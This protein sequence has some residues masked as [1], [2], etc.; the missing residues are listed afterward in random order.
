MTIKI[1]KTCLTGLVLLFFPTQIFGQ[2][3]DLGAIEPFTLFTVD[4]AVS[5]IGTSTDTGNI[6]TNVGIISGFGSPTSLIGSIYNANSITAQAKIDLL[7]V[8]IIL[9]NI[10]V[11]NTSHAPAFGNETVTSGVYLIA[12]AG[13]LAGTL[14][15]N[16]QG[17]PDAVFIFKFEGAFTAAVSAAIVLTNGARPSNVF[18][19]GE[20][21]ISIG[22]TATMKG[23]FIA[24]PG[25]VTLG[26]NSTLEGRMLSTS[27]AITV[28]DGIVSKPD[29]LSTIPIECV[30]ICNDTFLKSVANFTLFSSAGAVANTGISGV[31]G[32]IGSDYGAVSG[33]AS[34]I[35]IG[36][37]HNANSITAQAKTDLAAAYSKL[38]SL[39]ATDSSHTPAFGSGDTLTKG[40]YKISAAGSLAGNLI[41]DGKG[42]STALFV[43]KFGGAFSTATGSKVILINGARRCNIFW[44]AEGAISM[45]AFTFM[46]GTTIANNGANNMGANGFIEGRM[47]STAG[48]VGFYT[49]TTFIG[50]SLCGSG[51][52]PLP[53]ELTSFTG[54]C[55]QQNT[56][57]KWSTASERNNSFF[58]VER[59]VDAIHWDIIGTVDGAVNSF[60]PKSYSFTDFTLENNNYYYKL[61]QTDFDGKYEYSHLVFVQNC[62][63]NAS[64]N[65]IFYPNPNNGKFELKFNEN[66]MDPNIYSTQIYSSVGQKVYEANGTQTKFDLSNKQAGVYFAHVLLGSK[67]VIIKIVIQK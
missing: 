33:W 18:W 36:S 62:E 32:D 24:H 40:V 13:S 65:F 15:L 60:A 43:F 19:I 16:G 26:A 52:T 1:L 25:A 55:D 30:N 5:N 20:G 49:A 23:T 31:I 47:L 61:K 34:S 38:V 66:S 63:N 8:Y 6:G 7:N 17:N 58:T 56:I 14:T 4:G 50:Y 67:T 51:N 12:G 22:A 37:I 39:V 28:T 57:L 3:L 48:A 42:D 9:N 11:T 41:L 64:E 35:T 29:S 46:K 27:G 59:S 21:A 54:H 44:L 53:I 45:G 2:K 10:R